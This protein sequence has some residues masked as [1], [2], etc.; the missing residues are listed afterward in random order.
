ML[1]A[2]KAALAQLDVHVSH[3]EYE[4]DATAER[5]A[6]EASVSVPR[7]VE[8]LSL[9]DTLEKVTGVLKVRVEPAR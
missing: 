7:A 5:R 6:Y 1:T 4:F 8:L 2:A 3:E 9:V